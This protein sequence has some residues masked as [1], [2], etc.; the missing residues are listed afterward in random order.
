MSYKIGTLDCPPRTIS[1]PFGPVVTAV[2]NPQPQ[3]N[4]QGSFSVGANASDPDP[5]GTIHQVKFEVYDSAGHYMGGTTEYNSPYCLFGDSGGTCNMGSPM[6]FWPNSNNRIANGTYTIQIQ[7][8]D[9][10]APVGQMT[11]IQTT[12]TINATPC[13]TTGTGLLGLFYDNMD[14]TNLM[15]IRGGQQVHEN[16]GYG[17]P[18]PLIDPNTFSVRWIGYIQPLFTEDYTIWTYG[19]DGI[20]V[21]INGQTVVNDWSNHSTRWRSGTI[22]LE[23]CQ[24]Y[25]IT[26][27]YYE[28]TGNAVAEMEWSSASQPQGAVPLQNLYPGQN[29]LTPTARTPTPT[30]TLA[31]PTPTRTPTRTATPTNTPRFRTNT[32]TATTTPT[33]TPQPTKLFSPSD[34][35]K[36]TST[37]KPTSTSGPV[38]A[39]NT[40]TPPPTSTTAPPTTPPTPCLTPWDMGGCH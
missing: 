10:D 39:T 6:G 25:P 31:P 16:W 19:D 11:R 5:G 35:P 20:R 28:N 24:L 34:T 14:F 1:G 2:I 18:S 15:I 26:V 12:I 40:P 36:P 37:K 17:S 7:A 32:P 33:P 27:E 21:M 23:R 13:N 9:N 4:L 8:L 22:S 30:P 38:P 29:S 3:N